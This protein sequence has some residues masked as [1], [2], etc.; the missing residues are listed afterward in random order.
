MYYVSPVPL[1][2]PTAPCRPPHWS[3]SAPVAQQVPRPRGDLVVLVIGRDVLKRE[4]S[5]QE[6]LTE[7]LGLG[8]VAL[9]SL[10][11]SCGGA[12][13]GEPASD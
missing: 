3:V 2:A 9:A 12:P 4:S 6:Q 7:L 11:T 8:L 10:A 13:H 1:S 5:L